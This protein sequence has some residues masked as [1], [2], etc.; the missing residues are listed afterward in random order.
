MPVVLAC[1]FINACTR[2]VVEK[3]RFVNLSLLVHACVAYTS[4]SGKSLSWLLFKNT[5]AP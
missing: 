3:C 1:F 4:I 2:T 5:M